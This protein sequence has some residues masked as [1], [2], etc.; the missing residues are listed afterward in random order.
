MY[1]VLW[2]TFVPPACHV[3]SM[4]S[5]SFSNGLQIEPGVLHK[6]AETREL[7]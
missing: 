1:L 4:I 6:D 3:V 2:L 7:R 5:R